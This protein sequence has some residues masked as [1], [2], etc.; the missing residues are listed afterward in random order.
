MGK[1]KQK[2]RKNSSDI[3]GDNIKSTRFSGSPEA[4]SDLVS[5]TIGKFYSVL[6]PTL[7]TQGNTVSTDMNIMS[8][9]PSMLNLG[10]MGSP[11]ST[12]VTGSPTP[13]AQSGQFLP[14]ISQVNYSPNPVF[15]QP[16]PAPLAAGSQQFQTFPSQ[17]SQKPF[18]NCSNSDII[19]YLSAIDVKLMRVNNKLMTLDSVERKINDFDKELKKYGCLWKIKLNAPMRR[20]LDCQTERR[21]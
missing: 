18:Y 5:D 3:G 4:V 20:L 1:K 14:S 10:G 9:M 13:G 17:I 11:Q 6:Y 15:S 12:Y 21:I 19:R 7:V 8:N 2:K 16:Q